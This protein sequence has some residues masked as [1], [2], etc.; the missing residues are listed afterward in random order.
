MPCNTEQSRGRETAYLCGICKPVQRSA[1]PDRTLVM[2][3][4]AVRVRSSALSIRLTYAKF[5]SSRSPPGQR[6]AAFDTILIPPPATEGGREMALR[7]S[8]DPRIQE[9]VPRPGVRKLILLV[10][11]TWREGELDALARAG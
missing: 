2:S 9:F 11:G 1:T 4:S 10:D 3:R 8:W 6:R 5:V 7:Y